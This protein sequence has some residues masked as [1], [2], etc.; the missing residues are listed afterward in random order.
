MYICFVEVES[1]QDE[2]KKRELQE[3]LEEKLMKAKRR[4]LGNIR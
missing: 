3:E 2:T 1:E 4:S